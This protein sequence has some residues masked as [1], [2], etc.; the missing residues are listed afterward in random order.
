MRIVMSRGDGPFNLAEVI[1]VIASY[2]PTS[3]QAQFNQ[4]AIASAAC[5][6][7][8]RKMVR[9]IVKDFL[10]SV[11]AHS[12]CSGTRLLLLDTVDVMNV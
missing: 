12:N 1:E 8:W 11:I 5:N 7:A 2:L 10:V 4:F 3:P 9:G 6:R